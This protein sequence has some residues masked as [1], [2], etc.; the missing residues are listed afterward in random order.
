MCRYT[1]LTWNSDITN[2][3]CVCVYYLEPSTTTTTQWPPHPIQDDFPSFTILKYICVYIL[4]Q[5]CVYIVAHTHELRLFCILC[6]L[7]CIGNYVYICF[8][9]HIQYTY[10]TYIVYTIYIRI[11]LNNVMCMLVWYE[12]KSVHGCPRHGSKFVCTLIDPIQCPSVSYRTNKLTLGL[13]N[14]YRNLRD[15]L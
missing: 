13:E 4:P 14:C 12:C 9:I 2:L 6:I 10:N 3:L 1:Y 8:S 15:S 7:K 5:S 11:Y